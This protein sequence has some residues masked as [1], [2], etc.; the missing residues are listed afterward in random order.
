MRTGH[1]GHHDV[2]EFFITSHHKSHSTALQKNNNS[3][4]RLGNEVKITYWETK[5]NGARE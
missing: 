1:L 5:T 4:F 2:D 3:S